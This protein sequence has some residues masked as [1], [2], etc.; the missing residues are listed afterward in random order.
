MLNNSSLY[1]NEI[2]EKP[3]NTY[4]KVH[5]F[6][7]KVVIVGAG[8]CGVLLAHHL[9]RRGGQYKIEIYER[10][11]DPRKV[12]LSNS[13]TIPY[14][15][16]ERGLRAL[17][18]IPGLEAALK[19]KCVENKGTIIHRKSG[20]MQF[21]SRKQPI[22]NTD[23]I[24]VVM[25]LLSH[26]EESDRQVKINFNYQCHSVDFDAKQVTFAIGAE[27]EFVHVD[28]DILIG[29]DGARST[30]RK[31]FLNSDFFEFEQK[32]ANSCYK[33]LFISGNNQR[34][35]FQ[36]KSDC[37]HIWRIEEGITF[38]AVPQL[39][40][41]FIG[42]LFFPR[43]AEKIIGLNSKEDVFA[44]LQQNIPIV[45]E[46]VSEQEAENFVEKPFSTQ[47]KT[48]C[49]RFHHNDNVLII[50]DAIHAITSS[51]GQGCNVAF[52]DTFIFDNLL[53][54]YGDDWNLALEQFTICRQSDVYALWELDTNVYPSSKVLFTEFLL[55]E[56]FAKVM[57]KLS[58]QLFK[59]PLREV[60]STTTLSFS[61]IL[62]SHQGW[63]SKVKNANQKFYAEKIN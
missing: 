16:S 7:K 63:I 29:A 49:N 28:Y 2:I 57:H 31:H 14:G 10:R 53:D 52:E 33:T 41:N 15:I 4:L 32:Y 59:P 37:I 48:R 23:R 24:S 50:G 19:A 56:T 36:L 47:L 5:T 46:L 34:T 13:R 44:Y 30:V 60:L 43:N 58:P 42:L 62:K 6:M 39:D 11:S 22:Y 18:K 61:E 55:R 9:S 1:K 12:P 51:L 45:G 38:G 17:R 40:G 25:T 26:L 35:D 27:K 20:K 21:L 3:D 8:P 54:E